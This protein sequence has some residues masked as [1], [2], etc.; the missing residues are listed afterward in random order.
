L[1]RLKSH[2]R[3]TVQPEEWEPILGHIMTGIPQIASFFHT[4]LGNFQEMTHIHRLALKHL[5]S[6]KPQPV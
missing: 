2:G 6:S 4:R 3:L 1:A 5:S